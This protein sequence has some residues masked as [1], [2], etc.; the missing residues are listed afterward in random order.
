MTTSGDYFFAALHRASFILDEKIGQL[1]GYRSTDCDYISMV[2]I[3][4]GRQ[5]SHFSMHI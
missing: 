2:M 5:R 1:S 4:S 3:Y